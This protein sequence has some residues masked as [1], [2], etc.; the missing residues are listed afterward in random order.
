MPYFENPQGW[1]PHQTVQ[2]GETLTRPDSFYAVIAPANKTAIQSYEDYKYLLSHRVTWMIRQWAED[3]TMP[4]EDVYRMIRQRLIRDRVPDFP[5][6]RPGQGSPE[7]YA[8]ALVDSPWLQTL[9]AAVAPETY[10][11]PMERD[12]ENRDSVVETI[13]Y[14]TLEEWLLLFTKPE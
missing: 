8:T 10:P 12:L 3:Q 4:L 9:W 2:L 14:Q 5:L 7:S 13:Q 1:E 11:L 6:P